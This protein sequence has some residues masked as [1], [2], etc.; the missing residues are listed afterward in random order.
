M[1]FADLLCHQRIGRISGPVDRDGVIERLAA[2]LARPVEGHGL[3]AAAVAERLRERERLASTALG[4]GV[5]IPHA[6]IGGLDRAR[7]AFVLLDHGVSY[8]APDGEPVDL[9]FAMAVPEDEVAGHLAH[10]GEIAERFSDADFRASLRAADDDRE[11]A[12]RLLG[13]DA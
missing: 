3:A 6:R 10:L 2:L 4:H 11:L 5:A 8:A 12:R 9:V 1:P 7:G 13:A